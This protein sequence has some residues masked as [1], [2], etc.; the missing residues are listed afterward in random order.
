VTRPDLVPALKAADADSGGKRR[1][2][3]RNTIVAGQVALSLVLLAVAAS[4]V[5]GF[6]DEF[7][8]GPGYRT[9]HL[10]LTS[11]DTQ[12]AHYSEEQ[13]RRYYDD[14]LHRTR[15]APGV[16]SAALVSSVPMAPGADSMD[17]VPEGSTLPRGE[18]APQGFG[19]YISDGYFR[20]VGIPIV[21]GRGFLESDRENAPRVAV[22][23]QY[24][25][26]HYWPKGDALGK[27]FHLQG[28][29]GELVQ[30]VGIAR[31]AKYRSISE[32]PTDFVY[33]PVRQHP[34]SRMSLVA[35]SDAADAA[36]IAPVVREVVRSL[37]PDMPVFDVR[38]MHDLYTQRNV[39]VTDIIVQV[40][41]ALGL[42]GL[43]LA[44]VGLYGLVAYSVSRRTR[45]IGIRMAIGADRRKVVWMVLRQGLELG[46]AGV[47][48]G[49]LVSFF[50]CR[51]V[52]SALSMVTFERI[53]PLIFAVLPLLLVLVT[54][55][56]TWAPARRASLIDPMRALR[57]E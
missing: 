13:A 41:A 49:V 57:D 56:A 50:A 31:R 4:L 46:V 44:V 5:Q 14:L 33:L 7:M 37:D 54:V 45:E 6:R 26:M 15:S 30:I 25:A 12:L 24:T 43:L 21:E 8:Q 9:D 36:T 29:N 18:K 27:R 11:F 55:L 48:A 32:P 42:M 20:T 52:T 23:N 39:K 28:A 51:M 47:A 40:V 17:I 16:R 53:D 10:F 22:V 38:T 3:G 2:W 35:E 1:M 34:R 19:A